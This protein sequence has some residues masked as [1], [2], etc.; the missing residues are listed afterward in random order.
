[1]KTGLHFARRGRQGLSKLQKKMIS[2]WKLIQV[3]GSMSPSNTMSMKKLTL[4]STQKR[5]K[6][7][8]NGSQPGEPNCPVH[9]L[10]LY[11]L[12]LH[13]KQIA[14][15]Q[16]PSAFY[17]KPSSNHDGD[18]WYENKP[19]GHNTIPNMEHGKCNSGMCCMTLTTQFTKL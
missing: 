7:S 2:M 15:Y 5:P 14:F 4:A 11:V 16:K 10:K 8:N 17:Q 12:K 9:S 1:M 13:P 18:V 3:A 19:L 6:K